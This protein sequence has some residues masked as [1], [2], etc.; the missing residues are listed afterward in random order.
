MKRRMSEEKKSEKPLFSFGVIADV[1]YADENDKWDFHHT[2]ERHYRNSLKN[3]ISA[4]ETWKKAG[5][6][7]FIVQLG[8]L[9]DGL[10]FSKG[11]SE[12]SLK[13]VLKEFQHFPV[14]HLIGNHEL[15][16]FSR[17]K[18]HELLQLYPQENGF[19][20]FS[21][22]SG[23]RFVILDGY[24]FSI[25]NPDTREEALAYLSKYNPNDITKTGV[26]LT[27]NLSGLDKR[28]LPCNGGVSKKQLNWL[29]ETLSNA[30]KNNEKVIILSHIP[31]GE[32]SCSDHNLIWNYDEI[33]EIIYKYDC[34][35]CCLAGHDHKGGYIQD[36]KGIH[37]KTFESP[38]ETPIG[39]NAF[40]IINVFSDKLVFNGFGVV[41]SGI[42]NF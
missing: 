9:I 3:L 16:N 23:W 20:D 25:I 13:T 36:H 37:H 41:K 6:I 5:N 40:G 1:Q 22:L 18:L 34:V 31:I 29:E 21:P 39:L 28:F 42:W 30:S 2:S 12:N 11:T 15:Y 24:E 33:I 17:T 26:D 8:D 38:L 7:S 10:N 14:Y 35:I 32:G 4:V 19:Y 27:K